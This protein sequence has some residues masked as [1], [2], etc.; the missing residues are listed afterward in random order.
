MERC[1]AC[2]ADAVGTGS[3]RI[4]REGSRP[5][6]PWF[7]EPQMLFDRAA[8]NISS[9]LARFPGARGHAPSP[10]RNPA[11]AGLRL[12]SRRSVLYLHLWKE[13]AA[14][15]QRIEIAERWVIEA[16]AM[17][18]VCSTVTHHD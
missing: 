17:N 8:K 5:R 9:N 16:G 11:S 6:D 4:A 12:L 3:E 13:G 10:N 2:E 14:S 1:L 15:G 18:E 7:A